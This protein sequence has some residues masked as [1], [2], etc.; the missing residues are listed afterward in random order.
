MGDARSTARVA[1]GDRCGRNFMVVYYCHTTVGLLMQN[2][3]GGVYL[4][5]NLC[6]ELVVSPARGIVKCF[7]K[8][9]SE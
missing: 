3:E 4:T 1:V 8:G 6:Y 7:S 9:Y 5:V 2:A